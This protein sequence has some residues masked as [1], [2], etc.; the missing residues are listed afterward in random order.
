LIFLS[1]QLL[2]FFA[3]LDF[4]FFKKEKLIYSLLRDFFFVVVVIFVAFLQTFYS[5][6][7]F[8]A[9]F[10][11]KSLWAISFY[12]FPFIKQISFKK[13][14]SCLIK[15][16]HSTHIKQQG[17]TGDCKNDI[18]EKKYSYVVI[19]FFSFYGTFII[20]IS[21]VFILKLLFFWVSRTLNIQIRT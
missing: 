6:L 21:N 1:R 10:I 7:Q 12:F 5:S 9:K 19:I 15:C 4:F 20:L 8:F 2:F 13:W 14:M 17:G 11:H 18:E 3:N 16:I